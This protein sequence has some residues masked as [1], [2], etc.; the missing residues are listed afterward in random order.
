MIFR[1]LSETEAERFREYARAHDP[2]PGSWEIYHPVCREEWTRL[3]KA[4]KHDDKGTP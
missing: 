2:E 1:E 3:G 4:P